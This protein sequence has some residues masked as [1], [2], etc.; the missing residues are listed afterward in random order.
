MFLVK[1]LHRPFTVA[2]RHKFLASSRHGVTVV[3]QNNIN[4]V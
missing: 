2:G 3:S 1:L 4:L